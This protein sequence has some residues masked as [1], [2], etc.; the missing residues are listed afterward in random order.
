VQEPSA[1]DSR[2]AIKIGEAAD[3]LE[4]SVET[5][6]R[7]IEA[8]PEFE[9]GP[10]AK[11]RFGTKWLL[12]I[13]R[14]G[15]ARLRTKI[16]P[17]AERGWYTVGALHRRTG[18]SRDK[19]SSVAPQLK[20]RLFRSPLDILEWAPHYRESDINRELGTRE[21]HPPANGWLTARVIRDS[22]GVDHKWL[23]ENIDFGIM[24]IRTDAAGNPRPH[25]PPEEVDRLRTVRAA[26]PPK[27]GR[28]PRVNK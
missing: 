5:L 6:T 28:P 1:D 24:E 7:I 4:V 18:W 15:Y 19:I 21:Q 12:S 22:L 10:I 26:N 3:L 13:P 25:W 20:R 9:A 17:K 27:I 11:R 14:V 8:H 23:V 2:F 16:P